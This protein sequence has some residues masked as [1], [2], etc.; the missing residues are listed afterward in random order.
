MSIN[1]CS[2]KDCN[3]IKLIDDNCAFCYVN[4]QQINSCYVDYC[5]L[6]FR[7]DFI[8]FTKH[9]LCRLHKNKI[10]KC[11]YERCEIYGKPGCKKC[12]IHY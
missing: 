7:D 10:F 8:N 6:T 4:S 2:N 1:K 5:E 9:P 11:N 3:R 12:H